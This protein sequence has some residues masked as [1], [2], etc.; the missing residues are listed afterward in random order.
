VLRYVIAS[1]MRSPAASMS[2]SRAGRFGSIT[3]GCAPAGSA[4]ARPASVVTVSTIGAVEQPD[5][6]KNIET[7]SRTISPL[8]PD[9]FSES[10]R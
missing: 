10:F 1:A 6:V 3:T 7:H 4:D 9:I 2:G 8:A 5:S